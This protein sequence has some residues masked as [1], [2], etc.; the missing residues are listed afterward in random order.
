MDGGGRQLGSMACVAVGSIAFVWGA[1]P[2]AALN[3]TCKADGKDG[4]WIG[5]G[6]GPVFTANSHGNFCAAG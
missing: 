1:W 5:G 4:A 6:G 2:I 3:D